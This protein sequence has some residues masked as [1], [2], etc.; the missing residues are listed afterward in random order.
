MK[1]FQSVSRTLND[2]ILIIWVRIIHHNYLSFVVM[3][4]EKEISAIMNYQIIWDWCPN[5]KAFEQ[6]PSFKELTTSF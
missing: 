1:K 4:L 6:I 2:S 3:Y 5:L